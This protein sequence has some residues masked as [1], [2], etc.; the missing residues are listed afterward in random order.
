M[1]NTAK[2]PHRFSQ[3]SFLRYAHI[4]AAA[5]DAYPSPIIVDPAPMK[6]DSFKQPLR[7]AF[8]AKDR[9]GWTYA[10]LNETKYTQIGREISIA[11]GPNG[12]VYVGVYNS[13]KGHEKG[14]VV[15]FTPQTTE[16]YVVAPVALERLLS[17]IKID[18][19][20]PIPPFVVAIDD[21]ATIAKL[22][23]AYPNIAL[24]PDDKRPGFYYII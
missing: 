12:M 9:Y 11:D 1:T 22:N 4:I 15:P 24:M 17:I 7:D 10:R 14:A 19:I 18:G 21:P 13:G 3:A 8:T 23:A 16:E 6:A 5:V 20:R 2:I